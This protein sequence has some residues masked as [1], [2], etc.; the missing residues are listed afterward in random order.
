MKANDAWAVVV[1]FCLKYLTTDQNGMAKFSDDGGCPLR[2]R[3]FVVSG[4]TA[5]S[6]TRPLPSQCGTSQLISV[7]LLEP[8]ANQTNFQA[9]YFLLSVA[10]F[11]PDSSPSSSTS[12]I[13]TPSR[14]NSRSEN[15]VYAH[16]QETTVPKKTDIKA[17]G[18]NPRPHQP[19]QQSNNAH[20]P[21]LPRGSLPP[22]PLRRPGRRPPS[23]YQRHR[24]RHPGPRHRRHPCPQLPHLYPLPDRRRPQRPHVDRRRRPGHADNLRGLPV[25]RDYCEPLPLS[26][27]CLS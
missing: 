23:R 12:S 19:Y 25:C 6:P 1:L 16:F 24:P 11:G 17:Q 9:K 26:R 22:R 3:R 2:C 14:I 8:V 27:V 10:S 4:T 18:A 7:D 20:P 5:I 21:P 13:R 15:H